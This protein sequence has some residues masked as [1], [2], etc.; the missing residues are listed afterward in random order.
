M[1]AHPFSGT[2][3]VREPSGE[4]DR[5]L[6]LA[7]TSAHVCEGAEGTPACSASEARYGAMISTKAPRRLPVL[8]LAGFAACF[9][10]ACAVCV[11]PFS[12]SS[13]NQGKELSED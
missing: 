4:A 1:R 7:S 13:S 6:P 9:L 5:L 8:L 10:L 2:K 12:L 3:H 11:S